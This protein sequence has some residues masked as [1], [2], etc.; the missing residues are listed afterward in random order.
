M[1]ISEG[2]E[3]RET[4]FISSFPWMTV[5]P[6]ERARE[7]MTKNEPASQ[8][9]NKLEAQAK[10][11]FTLSHAVVG[12]AVRHVQVFESIPSLESCKVFLRSD[13]SCILRS[14]TKC[15]SIR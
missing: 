1:A 9:A 12:S 8:R 7:R 11:G 5:N 4:R 13:T 6:T 15:I 2:C 14:D 3:K 10:R